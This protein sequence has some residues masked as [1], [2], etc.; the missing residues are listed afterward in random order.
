[1][2]SFVISVEVLAV[3]CDEADGKPQ[4]TGTISIPPRR[5][6]DNPTQIEVVAYGRAARDLA[7]ANG[8]WAILRGPLRLE[9]NKPPVLTANEVFRHF[10][11]P[12]GVN[13]CSL[14]GRVGRDPEVR[15]FE[16]GSVVANL[17][18]AAKRRKEE[19]PDWFNLSIWGKQAQ[20]AADYVRKGSLI[21]ITGSLSF[22]GWTDRATGEQRSKPVVVAD[23]LELLGSRR[24]DNSQPIEEERP[25]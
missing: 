2:N 3:S 11:D 21:G 24:D 10:Q 13:T 6:D 19:P 9:K 14:V 16:S 22:D 15:Y 20:V 25:F 4:A 5:D 23:R 1:M 12:R 8:Q 17:T 7:E 18:L